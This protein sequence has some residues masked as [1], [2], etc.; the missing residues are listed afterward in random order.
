MPFRGSGRGSPQERLL[1]KAII[2]KKCLPEA[3]AEGPPGKAPEQGNYHR[4][5]HRHDQHHTEAMHISA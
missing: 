2:I 3:L 4:Y 5:D 1:N